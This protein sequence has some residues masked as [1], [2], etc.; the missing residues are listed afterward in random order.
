[1]IRTI[2]ETKGKVT[3]IRMERDNK[4]VGLS[5]GIVEVRSLEKQEFRSIGRT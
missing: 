4:I 5:K 1:M 3:S 2:S